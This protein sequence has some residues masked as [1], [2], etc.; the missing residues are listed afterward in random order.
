[1]RVRARLIAHVDYLA[2]RGT[3]TTLQC[4]AKHE[5]FAWEC[6][7][8]DPRAWPLW[9]GGTLRVEPVLVSSD[10]HFLRQCVLAGHGIALVPDAMVPDPG[11]DPDAVVPVLDDQVGRDIAVRIVVPSV[12]TEVPRIKALLNH[13]KAF[14]GQL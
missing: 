13:V 10:I 7:D 1:M 9:S 12:L 5:L 3:P 4:L 14:T 8:A 11:T 2:R 6:P